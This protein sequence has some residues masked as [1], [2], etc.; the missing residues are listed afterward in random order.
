MKMNYIQNKPYFVFLGL[1][2]VLLLYGFYKGN[3]TIVLNIHATYFVISWKHLMILVSF[4]CGILALGY[5]GMLKLNFVLINWMTVSHV[6]ISLIGLFIVFIL[7]KFFR[8]IVPGDILSV[9]NDSNFNQRIES[10]ILILICVLLGTQLLF[11]ANVIFA[12]IKGRS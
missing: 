4:F 12:L 1:I 11:F 3:E 10:G 2:V 6:L 9:I 8:E 5:F 7:P